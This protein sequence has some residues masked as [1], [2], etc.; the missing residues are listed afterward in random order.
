MDR[1]T[2]KILNKDFKFLGDIED[3]ISF[4]FIRSF[5]QAKE[6]QLIVPIRY[7]YL[8]I[9]GN[10]I[11]LSKYKSMIIEEIE[12]NEED[13][14]I[15]VKGRDIKSI[16]ERRVTIPPIGSAY[17]EVKGSAEEVIKHYIK[18]NCITPVDESRKILNLIIAPN[19]G[20]G[21][22]IKWQSRYKNLTSE[23]ESIARGAGIGWFIYIDQKEKKFIF[24]VE[25]GINRS[26]SQDE[27]SRVVFSSNFDN[28]SKAVHKSGS[29]S[30]K[31][32]GYVGGQGEG[33]E[34]EIVEV[35]K[36]NSSGLERREI[37][38][39]ARD[40][41][42]SGNLEDRGLTKL[43][44]YDYVVNTESTVLNNNLEYER[45]WNIGDLVTVKSNFSKNN[46]RV[47]EVREIY[48]GKLTVEIVV[49]TVEGNVLER[50]NNNISNMQNE[51]STGDRGGDR[52][53][54]FNQISPKELWKIPH[55]LGKFP[56]VTI[57]DSAGSVVL[58]EINHIDKNNVELD[59]TAA[60]SGI[61]YLN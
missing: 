46:L 59:F 48:E 15:I 49:G 21:G 17:D 56:S 6:F 35:R 19:K 18:N 45:D 5:F 14:Q 25:I 10:Y 57:T 4:Y 42:E 44:E 55:G 41:S 13:S 40:I 47:T 43:S 20:R 38:I 12:I 9:E 34:R 24:D 36:S 1:N 23:V 37:F 61:A 30:Y 52:S 51:T 32:I 60:F 22:N 8:L 58:G 27:N 28:I 31:N 26:E 7:S 53:Y 29:L 39:D 3:Y 33:I 54:T 50:I 11:Y 16:L 2:L